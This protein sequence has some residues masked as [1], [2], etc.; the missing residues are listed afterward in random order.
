MIADVRLFLGKSTSG[1]STLARFQLRARPR[2]LI[3]DPNMEQDHGRGA[4]LCDDPD[5]LV[6]LVGE[7]GAI[8]ICWRGF[9]T[10]DVEEAFEWG[11]RAAW[12][13]EGFTVL[14]DEVDRYLPAGRR[15]PTWADRLINAGRHRG[16]SIFAAARRPARIAPDLRDAATRI[17]VARI[18]GENSLGYLRQV[19]GLDVERIPALADYEFLDWQEAA[20]SAVK[21]SPFD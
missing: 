7:R 2:V 13:G 12:A 9:A 17:C 3:F 20:G 16:C 6:Q 15:F 10:M 14:W 1:K 5:H 4:V 8:R 21:K 19:D 18:T 11:N